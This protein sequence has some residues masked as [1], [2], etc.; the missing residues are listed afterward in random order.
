MGCE[1]HKVQ[2]LNFVD[3]GSFMK[4]GMKAAHED[5]TG[6]Y[7]NQFHNLS[8]YRGHFNNTGP[9]IWEQMQGD[10]DYF[11]TGA[12]TGATLSGVSNFLKL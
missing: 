7:S 3:A 2:S 4:M 8:N 11:I 1:L 9:E 12:G 6:F 10:I 5:P